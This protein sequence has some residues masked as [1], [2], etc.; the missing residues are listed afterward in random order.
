MLVLSRK[1]DQR[2]LI[3]GLDIAI[4][5][6]RCKN[7][8]VTLGFEAPSEVRIARD[9]LEPE[10]LEADPDLSLIHI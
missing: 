2:V 9:E 8:S 3:P 10:D 5:V 7:A 6:I 1:E 4:K